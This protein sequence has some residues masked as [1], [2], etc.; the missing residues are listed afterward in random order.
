MEQ[1]NRKAT[2]KQQLIGTEQRY[3]HKGVKHGVGKCLFKI[4]LFKSPYC[5]DNIHTQIFGAA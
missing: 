5:T 4:Y 1:T 3:S 2:L